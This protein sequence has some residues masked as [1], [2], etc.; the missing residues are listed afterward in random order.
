MVKQTNLRRA[1]AEWL[2]WFEQ[3]GAKKFLD[4]CEM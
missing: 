3:Y 1:K 4:S 2:K